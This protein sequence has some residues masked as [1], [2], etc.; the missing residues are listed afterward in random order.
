MVS[1]TYSTS[2]YVDIRDVGRVSGHGFRQRD[3]SVF[4]FLPRCHIGI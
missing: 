3:G 2:I 4:H 1:S